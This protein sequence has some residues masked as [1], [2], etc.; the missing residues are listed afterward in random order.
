[1]VWFGWSRVVL[2]HVG[3]GGVNKMQFDWIEWR[4]GLG[5]VE[6]S[7]AELVCLESNLDLS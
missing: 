7:R 6:W 2:Y 3:V 1:M 5:L 4:L